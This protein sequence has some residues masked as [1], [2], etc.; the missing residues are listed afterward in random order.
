[1]NS[2]SPRK[3]LTDETDWNM[4]WSYKK[5][6]TETEIDIEEKGDPDLAWLSSV[7]QKTYCVKRNNR[8]TCLQEKLF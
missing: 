2:F 6:R 7:G 3:L 1:M 8:K 4:V 5:L